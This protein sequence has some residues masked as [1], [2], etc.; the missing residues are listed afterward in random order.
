MYSAGAPTKRLSDSNPKLESKVGRML[1]WVL[2]SPALPAQ[3]GCTPVHPGSRVQTSVTWT[4]SPVTSDYH[5]CS[6]YYD[7]GVFTFQNFKKISHLNFYFTE[8]CLG[9]GGLTATCSVALVTPSTLCLSSTSNIAHERHA[10]H[11]VCAQADC[12][13]N[14]VASYPSQRR[15]N[16]SPRSALRPSHSL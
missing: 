8:C 2:F 13:F 16:A 12:L 7:R 11:N 4:D 1:G 14:A 5:T 6:T 3:S 15:V 9:L 10:M